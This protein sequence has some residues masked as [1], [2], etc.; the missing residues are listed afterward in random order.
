[1]GQLIEYCHSNVDA[2]MRDV[3]EEAE[4]NVRESPCLEQ[5]DQC[6][7][8]SFVLVG[9]EIVEISDYEEFVSSLGGSQ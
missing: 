7:Q 2:T 8:R 3:L 6:Y 5:C 1:M 9:G 4:Q